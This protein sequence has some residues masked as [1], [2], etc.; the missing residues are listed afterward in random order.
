M[1][2]RTTNDV[3]CD[4]C[5]NKQ[6]TWWIIYLQ[7]LVHRQL[8]FPRIVLHKI[9]GYQPIRRLDVQ[10]TITQQPLHRHDV[11][12]AIGYQ[13]V[14]R[15]DVQTTIGQYPLCSL[16]MQTTISQQPMRRL[17]VQTTIGQYPFFF[18]RMA[19]QLPGQ[20]SFIGSATVS[21]MQCPSTS[22]H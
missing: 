1:F 7:C 19:A 2:A 12:T 17:D 8:N 10:T 13:P 5:T 22:T 18:L 20:L 15:L 9:I 21:L 16:D 6:V 4:V 14:R 3:P 11:Q